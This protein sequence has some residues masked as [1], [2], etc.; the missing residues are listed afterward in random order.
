VHLDVVDIERV[1]IGVAHDA[2][3]HTRLIPLVR[4]GDAVRLSAVVGVC[5]YNDTKDGVLVGNGIFNTLEDDRAN[6][7]GTAVAAGLIIEGVAVS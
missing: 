2:L 7:I 5:A 3:E 1:D 4:A 6:S